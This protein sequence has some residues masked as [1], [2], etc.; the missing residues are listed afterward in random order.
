MYNTVSVCVFLCLC[1]YVS[2]YRE[3]PV[4]LYYAFIML[5]S[6]AHKLHLCIIY[7]PMCK[8]CQLLLKSCKSYIHFYISCKVTV[9]L[10]YVDLFH[11]FSI[12]LPSY[13]AN[14]YYGNLL[15]YVL[16]GFFMNVA[17]L[18]QVDCY[19]SFITVTMV[20]NL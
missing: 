6:V 13:Y 14:C 11:V 10:E 19:Q 8:I 16:Y 4:M 20:M 12:M 9:L 18:V 3:W 7:M 15:G 2:G 17:R 5:S 1:L